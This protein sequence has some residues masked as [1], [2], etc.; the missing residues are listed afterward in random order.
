LIASSAR[1]PSTFIVSPPAGFTRCTSIG[2]SSAKHASGAPSWRRSVEP[3]TLMTGT[4]P[5]CRPRASRS[6]RIRRPRSADRRAW[7]HGVGETG[8]MEDAAVILVDGLFGLIA[9]G[10][11]G[12]VVVW[13]MAEFPSGAAGAAMAA[14]HSREAARKA[15][16]GNGRVDRRW[17]EEIIGKSRAVGERPH[18]RNTGFLRFVNRNFGCGWPSASSLER[19]IAPNKMRTGGSSMGVQEMR[20]LMDLRQVSS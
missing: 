2:D 14:R 13:F 11:A 1:G 5:Q 7:T 6:P 20:F 12:A 10:V 17:A 15:L 9:V 18:H 16:T 3:P 19:S 4:P 8:A